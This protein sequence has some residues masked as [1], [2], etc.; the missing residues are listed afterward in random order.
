MFRSCFCSSS[1]AAS[2]SESIQLQTQI[3]FN[4][5]E[6]FDEMQHRLFMSV[7]SVKSF[8]LSERHLNELEVQHLAVTLEKC[9]A[10][11]K[12]RYVN[13]SSKWV[14]LLVHAVKKCSDLK[15]VHLGGNDINHQLGSIVHVLASCAKLETLRLNSN[16]I[17][18]ENVLVL[19]KLGH[20][21]SLDLG[22][23]FLGDLGSSSVLAILPNL[24]ELKM[25]SCKIQDEGA[26]KIASQ[27]SGCPKLK[28]LDLSYNFVGTQGLCALVDTITRTFWTRPL[29]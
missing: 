21:K 8:I 15:I 10:L 14:R 22:A 18:G 12:F 4:S 13:C 28:V 5:E 1:S 27:L 24:E 20:L 6:S 16:N 2:S 3:E 26:L 19:K 23:N 29:S 11:Q 25:N 9:F 17:Y 7:S